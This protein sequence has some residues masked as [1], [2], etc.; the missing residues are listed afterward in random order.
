MR[1]S[2][3]Q[4]GKDGVIKDLPDHTLPLTSWTDSSNMRFIDKKIQRIK[5]R[6]EVFATPTQAPQFLIPVRTP[7]QM[8]WV[9][10]SLTD[11]F[12]WDGTI[13][14]EITRTVGGDYSTTFGRDWNGGVFGGV[15]VATNEVD[16]P[17]YWPLTS[18]GTPLADLV[19]WPPILRARLI[20]PFKA[21]LVA[22]NLTDTGVAK[23]HRLRW[24]H[25]AD[26]GTVP[27]SW[28]ITDE[29]KDAGEVDLT[30]VQ[31]GEIKEALVLG[32][33]LVIYKDR[34]TWIMRFIGGA[35]IFRFE[36]LLVSSGI[37]AARCVCAVKKGS[38]HF[39]HNGFELVEFNG[40]TARALSNDKWARFLQ[41]D[42]DSVNYANSFC[43]ELAEQN[44]AY[45]CYP[46]GGNIFPN[47]ALVWNYQDDILYPVEFIGTFAAGGPIE[48]SSELIWDNA[49]VNWDELNDTWNI[50]QGEKVV[51]TDPA[52]T[53]FYI[54]EDGTTF[55]GTAF[56]SYVEKVGMS[57][58][59]VDRFGNPVV[60]IGSRKM[61]KRLWPKI[62]GGPVQIRFITQENIQAPIVYENP[63]V[64]NPAAGDEYVDTVA[65]GRLLGF[66]VEDIVGTSWE[67]D[68]YEIELE[69]LGEH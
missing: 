20:R 15:L 5:G 62:Q 31:S 58:T 12:V 26:P 46:S 18:V 68:G 2:I 66:R 53:R 3:Q 54:M 52:D 28:D 17:Q 45:F 60:D 30:D 44:E 47:K 57:M 48:E 42:L 14:T 67:F 55:M 32:D 25:S 33:S 10:F 38:S 1:L 43:F 13:H 7:A 37:L 59:G 19:N 34:S 27:N 63:I 50:A 9:Y 29:T 6:R 49:N 35:S 22:L 21:F 8:F 64:F 56:G 69:V 39:L 36:S 23:P 40:Q 24:S 61:V 4:V 51:V 65:N 11:A 41:S 16:V